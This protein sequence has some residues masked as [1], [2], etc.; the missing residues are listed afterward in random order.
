[1]SAFAFGSELWPRPQGP[2]SVPCWQ[3]FQSKSTERER[4][5]ET[6]GKSEREKQQATE[7]VSFV[8]LRKLTRGLGFGRLVWQRL[9]AL[10]AEPELLPLFRRF[11]DD[12][13]VPFVKILADGEDGSAKIL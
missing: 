8:F 6:G 4:E 11:V 13:D 2:P 1:M 7:H 9:E 5:R 10:R 12:A 3:A